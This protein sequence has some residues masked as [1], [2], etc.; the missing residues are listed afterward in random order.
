MSKYHIK[1]DGSIGICHAKSGKCPYTTHIMADIIEQAQIEAGAVA[2]KNQQEELKKKFGDNV[3]TMDALLDSDG[4]G[5]LAREQM[6][7]SDD[8]VS[9][10]AD[11]FRETL[12][13]Q[14]Y[15]T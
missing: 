8:I 9:N 15:S 2:Y 7:S 14:L 4:V 1:T 13:K 5:K 10:D 11:N 3:P 12:R 6:F